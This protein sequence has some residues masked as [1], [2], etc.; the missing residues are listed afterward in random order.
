M[1]PSGRIYNLLFQRTEYHLYPDF[2]LKSGEKIPFGLT[3]K[4]DDINGGLFFWT[5]DTL[6]CAM[7]INTKTKIAVMN[8]QEYQ[9][10]D[11]LFQVAKDYGAIKLEL[12]DYNFDAVF[13]LEHGE[14]RYEVIGFKPQAKWRE[15]YA[16]VQEEWET[17]KCMFENVPYED[18]THSLESYYMF[19]FRRIV[20]EKYI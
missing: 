5:T 6:V 3:L 15:D 1:R 4:R 9:I 12:Y 10:N 14:T 20:W 8:T 19:Q 7:Y 18:L 11:T 13:F 2:D 17:T 16:R